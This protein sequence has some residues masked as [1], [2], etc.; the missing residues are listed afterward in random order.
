MFGAVWFFEAAL[1]QAHAIN[2]AIA[3]TIIE[4]PIF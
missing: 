3:A 4:R 1:Q 2:A